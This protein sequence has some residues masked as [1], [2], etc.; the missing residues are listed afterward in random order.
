MCSNSKQVLTVEALDRCFSSEV[1]FLCPQNV[2]KAV[3]NLQSLDFARNP[4]LKLSFARN[5]LSAPNCD[6]IQ[7][8][9]HLGGRNFISTTSGSV[10]M[11]VGEMDIAPL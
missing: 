4:E 9:I 8:W 11:T 2:L 7:P 10:Q 5:H 6:H 1:G 3:T